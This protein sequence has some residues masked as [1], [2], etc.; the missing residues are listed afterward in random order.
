[1]SE[2]PK[3]CPKCGSEITALEGGL[4]CCPKCGF[5]GDQPKPEAKKSFSSPNKFWLALLAPAVISLVGCLIGQI[6]SGLSAAVIVGIVG[7]FVGLVNSIYCGYWLACRFS[8]NSDT[9]F[10][11]GL[12]FIPAIAAV[13]FFI[14][15]AGCAPTVNQIHIH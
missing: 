11:F 1:M 12:L 10:I 9:R 7:A 6:P 3:T 13:N 8:N 5:E 15:A 4:S 14:I 2:Q